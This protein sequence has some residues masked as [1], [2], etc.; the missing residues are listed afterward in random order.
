[1]GDRDRRRDRDRERDR[2]RDDRN[3]DQNVDRERDRDRERTRSKRLRTPDRTISHH[4]RSRTRSPDRYRSRSRSPDRNHRRTPSVSPQRKHHHHASEEDKGRHIAVSDYADEIMKQQQKK[5]NKEQITFGWCFFLLAIAETL[6]KL[7][8]LA[9]APLTVV[10]GPLLDKVHQEPNPWI[11]QNAICVNKLLGCTRERSMPKLSS[12][13]G[14][15]MWTME[16]GKEHAEVEFKVGSI[17]VDD[18]TGKGACRSWA[19]TCGRWNWERS[20]PKLSSRLGQYM[21]TMELGKEHAEVEFKVGPIHVDDGTGKEIITKITSDI[22]TNGIRD[23]RSD[24]DLQVNQPIA[25]NYYPINL[26]IYVQDNDTEQSLLVDR[27]L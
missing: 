22:K 5:K 10:R 27:S 19:N 25:G 17:H 20:M 6:G 11:S 16:L 4:T 21:W 14:Q 26:G 13:L 1:M 7:Q 2:Y 23:F 8:K 9:E 12:R 15:Y 3:T 18:G 24:W